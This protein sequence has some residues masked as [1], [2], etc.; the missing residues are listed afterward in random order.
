[1]FRKLDFCL[2]VRGGNTYSVGSLVQ[3]LRLALSK[4]PNRVGVSLPSRGL[5]L[6]LSKGPNRAGLT[7]P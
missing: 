6:D 3:R 5:R 1:M 7:L 2:Q 4:K